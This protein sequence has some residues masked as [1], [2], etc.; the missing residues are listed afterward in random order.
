MHALNEMPAFLASSSG[1]LVE[2]HGVST[3]SWSVTRD[4]KRLKFNIP[5]PAPI[6]TNI[7]S[8]HESQKEW[9]KDFFIP[10]ESQAS[11]FPREDGGKRN[12][13][14]SLIPSQHFVKTNQFLWESCHSAAISQPFLYSKPISGT[15]LY[16]STC[17]L[18]YFTTAMFQQQ[19]T[20]TQ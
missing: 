10:T 18:K 5:F 1:F 14:F 13:Y 9:K 11:I 8:K 4:R 6:L 17:R 16:T 3:I 15:V 2:I 19:N 20:V 7:L 12:T